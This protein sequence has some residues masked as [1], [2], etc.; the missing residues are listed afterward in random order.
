[1]YQRSLIILKPDAVHRRLIGTIIQRLENAGLQIHAAKLTTAT[2]E[3]AKRHYAEH[4]DK[5]FYPI[6]EQ[7]ILSG[8]MLLLVIGG[9]NAIAKI[10]LM[11]GNTIPHQ[12]VPGTIRGDFSHQGI[13]DCEKSKR[14]TPLRNLIHAS[15][16]SSEAE[17]EIGIWFSPEEILEYPLPDAELHGFS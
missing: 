16:N 6:L 4:I 2:P 10:R 12:A 13:P 17:H 15:A 7:Y 8:P 9:F 11:V 1:M 5:D 14:A 3:K